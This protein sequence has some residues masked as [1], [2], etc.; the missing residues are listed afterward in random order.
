MKILIP[1]ERLI[2]ALDFD[3]P[4]KNFH[5]RQW[6]RSQVRTLVGKLRGTGV[7]VKL[8]SALRQDDYDLIEEVHGCGLKV[9]ADLKLID[10]PTTLSIDGKLLADVQPELLT[11]MCSAGFSSMQVLKAALP[12]TE[13]LGVTVLTSFTDKDADILPGG[14]IDSAVL[15]Y[16]SLAAQAGIGGWVASPQE[17]SILKKLRFEYGVP[18]MTVNTPGIRSAW[19]IVSGDDQNPERIMTPAK[20]IQMGADRIIVGRPITLAKDP[21]DAMMRTIDEIASALAS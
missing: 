18:G 3:P 2:V 7:Y 11:V 6:V 19:A 4:E 10:I 13:V 15:R 1:P 16:A 21:Y 12:N 20:A 5:P 8:N 14:S 17:I 9:F